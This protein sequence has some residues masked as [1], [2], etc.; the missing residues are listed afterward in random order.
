MLMIIAGIPFMEEGNPIMSAIIG[1][2]APLEWRK[3]KNL[4]RYFLK[5]K[6]LNK[7]QFQTE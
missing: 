5:Q 7:W 1:S 3:Q 2:F 6:G 4:K